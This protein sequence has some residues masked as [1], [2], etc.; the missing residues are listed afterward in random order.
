MV[1]ER[2]DLKDV[3][4]GFVDATGFRVRRRE[5]VLIMEWNGP[6]GNDILFN[7]NMFGDR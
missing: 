2:V 1:E 5:A 6:N 4:I 3:S 7:C